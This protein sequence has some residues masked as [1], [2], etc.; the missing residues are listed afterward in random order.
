MQEYEFS[1]ILGDTIRSARER[2]GLT[3]EQLSAMIGVQSRTILNIENNRGNP[4]MEVLYPLI[5]TLKIDPCNIFY[6]ESGK[7]TSAMHQLQL[8]LSDCTDEE[9]SLLI[10]VITPVLAAFRSSQ[11]EKI[12]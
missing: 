8:L 1:R 9:I 4:K 12:Q 3:Q 6:P 11:A 10:S 5:R 7:N 2:S